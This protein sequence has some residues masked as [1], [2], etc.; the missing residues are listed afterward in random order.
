MPKG[1]I[2]I[3]ITPVSAFT[4][5]EIRDDINVTLVSGSNRVEISAGVNVLDNIEIIQKGDSLII[6]D[7]NRCNWVREYNEI[8][9]LIHYTDLETIRQAGSGL[10]S[11]FDTIRVDELNLIS[12]KRSGNFNLTMDVLSLHV[13]SSELT[14]FYLSGYARVA[15]VGFYNG[16]GRLESRELEVEQM[17]IYHRGSNDM[18]V[19]VIEKLFVQFD[20]TGNVIYYGGQPTEFE[21]I[22]NGYGQ[23]VPGD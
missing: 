6:Q 11:S 23:A 22:S 8:K 15:N 12:Q 16:D 19:N 9:V 20:A 17:G 21:V 2:T 18:L 13:L 14:N 3:E 10:I 4:Y 5:I 1:E 7:N